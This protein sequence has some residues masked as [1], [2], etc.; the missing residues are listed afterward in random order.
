MSRSPQRYHRENASK[1]K[2]NSSNHS[3]ESNKQITSTTDA[4]LQMQSLF[5]NQATINLTRQQGHDSPTKNRHDMFSQLKIAGHIPSTHQLNQH[6]IQKKE[7]NQQPD[8]TVTDTPQL[9]TPISHITND[10]PNPMIQKKWFRMSSIIDES[11]EHEVHEL[12]KMVNEGK[13][14]EAFW[15]IVK[16][17]P[18]HAGEF[19][20]IMHYAEQKS[21][22]GNPLIEGEIRKILHDTFVREGKAYT[23]TEIL[24]LIMENPIIKL[25]INDESADPLGEDSADI[26]GLTEAMAGLSISV[27]FKSDVDDENETHTISYS[28]VEDDIIVRSNAK[29]LKTLLKQPLPTWE[30]V[31]LVPGIVSTLE[32]LRKKAKLSLYKIAGNVK[33]NIKGSRSKP[34]M[35]AFRLSLEK[36][37]NVFKNIKSAT[38][39]IQSI[40]PTDLS[41]SVKS[42]EGTDVRA[43]PLSIN[44]KNPGSSPKDGRLMTA[45]RDVAGK[46]SKSYVQMHLLND[47]VFGPGELW[48]LTPGP[49]QS[50]TDMANGIEHH[51]KEAIIGKN[52]VINFRAQVNYKKDPIK[53]SDQEIEEHPE[54]YIFQTIKFSATQLKYN[55][56][57]KSWDPVPHASADPDVQAINSPASTVYWSYGSLPP[58]IP[59][60]RLFSGTLTVKELE[61]SGISHGA[62]VR[63]VDFLKHN[64]TWRPKKGGD[65]QKQLAEA[66]K[67]YDNKSRIPQISDWSANDVRWS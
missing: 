26:I 35:E 55:P 22:E 5:G 64:P 29:P 12:N 36:I 34:N 19:Q 67:A 53:A 51:L 41:N 33:R 28:N 24:D 13:I 15:E 45:I 20:K 62:A 37:A 60:P 4:V 38:K 42:I 6:E 63:I 16:K 2:S 21:L 48:N 59:K 32:A 18:P 1:Y 44:S 61:Q 7:Y 23:V 39:T 57:S 52:L 65:R 27:P 49:K 50:N 25:A 56:V 10:S 11:D 58:L 17:Y 8:D 31:P 66:V 54:R 3:H 9:H 47:L 43:E 30:G 46:H 14:L 40:P